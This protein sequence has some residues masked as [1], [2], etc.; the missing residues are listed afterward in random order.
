MKHKVVPNPQEET[1]R[2][3]DEEIGYSRSQNQPSA[4]LKRGEHLRRLF[5]YEGELIGWKPRKLA[6]NTSIFSLYRIA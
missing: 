3:F 1:F 2:A 6:K 4:G 5:A